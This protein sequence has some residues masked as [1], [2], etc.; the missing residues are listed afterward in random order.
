MQ[1]T[2]IQ[3]TGLKKKYR[4]GTI[5][6]TTLQAELSSWW[7]RKRGKEDPNSIVGTNQTKIG[8][9]FWALNGIDLEVRR[10]EALGIIG[11]NGAGKSTLLKLLSRVTAPTEGEIKIK[12]RIS[13]MLEVGTGFH[14][15]LTGR[16]NIYLNGA[17]LGMN[18]REVEE[19]I[20]DIIDFSECRRFIDTPVKRYSSGMYVKLAFAVSAFLDSEI[21][22]MDEVLAVGDMKFQEKCLN[23]MENSATK[24]DKTILYVSHNMS[25]IRKL[26]SRCIVLQQGKLIYNGNVDGAINVYMDRASAGMKTYYEIKKD[27]SDIS[28]I[29]VDSIRLLHQGDAGK[30]L[31]T[32]AFEFEWEMAQKR[33]DLRFCLAVHYADG[34]IAGMTESKSMSAQLDKGKH[35]TKMHFD[36]SNLIT[37]KYY[38]DFAI[39]CVNSFGTFEMISLPQSQP[40]WFEI[41]NDS[42]DCINWERIHWGNVRLNPLLID[43]SQ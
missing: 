22:V 24:E 23:K 34:S 18:K 2:V 17:I 7:A 28:G 37:G 20:E 25:T 3:I 36:A 42:E 6:G 21:M 15:E 32:I 10:G 30:F 29:R 31:H 19:K 35:R 33:E 16:E 1:E 12:G 11:M 41:Q 13:S 40:V 26:C 9:E 4:L 8:E 39:F 14:A 5:G 27:S 43:E 38:F